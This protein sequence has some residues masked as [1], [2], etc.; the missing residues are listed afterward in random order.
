M[1]KA[2]VGRKHHSP[3]WEYFDSDPALDNTKWVGVRSDGD[4]CGRRLNS[5]IFNLTSDTLRSIWKVPAVVE[6]TE[7][8]ALQLTVRQQQH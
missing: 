5:K 8:C 7:D 1:A 2:P 4:V 3:I 6:G